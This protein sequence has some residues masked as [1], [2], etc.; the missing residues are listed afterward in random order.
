MFARLVSW[1]AQRWKFVLLL[2]GVFVAIAFHAFRQL[3]IEAYPD[4]TDPMVEVVTLLPGQ[5][6]E[7]TE[8]Q[9]S[10]ELERVLAGAP[11]LTNIR[12]V[13]VF[14][15]SVVTLRF[16]DS[17]TDR[18]N[19][20][21][22]AERLREAELPE[23]VEALLGPQATPVGQIY[24][25]T[26]S[27]AR[28][29][30]DLRSLQDWVIERRLRAVPGV[31]DV[32]TF[33][34]V[35]RQYA[36]RIDPVRL[37]NAEITVGDVYDAIERSNQN[38]GGGYVGIGNQEFVVRG[39][40]VLRRPSDIGEA[41]VAQR[42]GVPIRVKDVASVFESSVPRRGAVGRNDLD[43]VVEGIVLLRRGENPERVLEALQEQVDELNGEI[44]PP[45]VSIH[46]FYDRRELT[47]YTLST[48]GNNL[49]HGA[50][51]VVSI[52]L[53]FLRSWSAALIIAC[54]IPLSLLSSFLGL[55]ALGMSANLISMGAID[56]GILVE[57]AAVLLEVTLHGLAVQ[58]AQSTAPLT[59]KLRRD[60]IAKAALLVARPIGLASMIIIL[61]LVPLFLLERVEGRIFRPMAFTYVFAL[62]GGVFAA[63]TVVPAMAGVLLPK[64]V[65]HGESRWLAWLQRLYA[66]T[67]AAV[68]PRRW[69]VLGA[70]IILTGAVGFQ[71][72]TIGSEFLPELNE[73]GL[74]ITAVFPPTISLD[75]TRRHVPEI[76]RKLLELP[77]AVEVLSH[78][79]RPDDA[80]QTEGPN[81]A[82]FFVKLAPFEDWRPAFGLVELEQELRASLREVPGVN[83]N[84]SQPITDRVFETISGIIGQVV[85]KVRG[86]DLDTL[87]QIAQQVQTR[88]A[89]VE[90]IADLSL[91]QAGSIPQIGIELDRARL[92][93]LGLNVADAQRVV[94][95]ALGGKVATEVWEGERRYGVA[96]RLPEAVRKDPQAIGR[97]VLGDAERRVQLSDVAHISS[98]LGRASIWRENLSR[99]VAVK[100]N[101]RGRDLGSV[102]ADARAAVADLE[103]PSGVSL[104]FSGEFE[105]QQRAMS[106]LSVIVPLVLLAMLG[107]LYW[108]FGRWRPAV[109]IMGFLPVSTIFALAGLQ[110]MGEHFSVSAAVGCITLLGQVTLAGVLLCT[111]IDHSAQEGARDPTVEGAT[112]ALR[113]VLLTVCLAAIG[114]VP[115][116]LSHGMGSESQRPFA[117]AI[118]S[119]LIATVPLLLLIL[120]LVHQ[121]PRAQT[122]AEGEADAS[123]SSL[124]PRAAAGLFVLLFALGSTKPIQAAPA[125]AQGSHGAAPNA[126]PVQAAPAPQLDP[127]GAASNAAPSPE[128]VTRSRDAS[129]PGAS[130]LVPDD[131]SVSVEQLLQHWLQHSQEVAAWRAEVG[132][133]RFDLVTARTFPNLE[134]SLEGSH[135][136][137][138]EPPDGIINY[139]ASLSVPLPVFGQL[140]ART[141]A[142]RRALD[143]TEASVAMRLWER[144]AQIR[145][146]AMQRAYAE[147]RVQYARRALDELGRVQHVIEARS[148]AG[149][150]PRYDAMRVGLLNETLQANEQLALL[151]RNHAEAVIVG[152]IGDP[153]LARANVTRDGL[154]QLPRRPTQSE[155]VQWALQ[156]RPDLVLARRSQDAAMAQANQLKRE[157]IPIPHLSVGTYVTRDVNSVSLLGGLSLPLPVFDRNQGPIGRARSEARGHE[158]MVVALE[159]RTRAEVHGALH[160]LEQAHQARQ[161]FERSGVEVTTDLLDRAQRAYEAGSFSITELLDAHSAVWDARERLLEM[162]RAV[163]EAELRLL[164]SAALGV[165]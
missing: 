24:R 108:N 156:R 30:R 98:T 17:S 130:H 151:D 104:R 87:T 100:F 149:V 72:R 43:D 38:A 83:Y 102:V 139:G 1:S 119:G 129:A 70:A 163:A 123:R 136:L 65:A 5:S 141:Q 118:I 160:S 134:L 132:A 80:T 155:V 106:R 33:G 120:P 109:V 142:A 57:N 54:V 95:V 63:L 16:D 154:P 71:S 147:A 97:L 18:A 13:S 35:E 78:I 59:A 165:R 79:G 148:R 161:R 126:A 7:E 29:L 46:P 138:G 23:G 75:E 26:L 31:A 9:V 107:I 137:S 14:G 150:A 101:V 110:L 115:A 41:L 64:R 124:L 76:R 92:G 146:A 88:L 82:E 90:G 145:E 158:R 91:Y 157:A 47:N 19:R 81:N 40:G 117:I 22:V 12:T 39:V 48:V 152:L 74:Y 133:A 6:A 2:T 20:L 85:V 143:A 11:H 32:V 21:H 103:L 69:T 4:V 159:A 58:Q 127:H 121:P 55:R 135:T 8:R 128:A 112:V 125:A 73:G 66:S 42:D 56:F 153:N 34:G 131:A 116:A 113:P 86:E 44:L 53:L 62:L 45:D 61:A 50:L 51:L 111:R 96:L 122:R 99:F 15:L 144:S 36:V 162:E 164:H 60:A 84:F 25:Y 3:P 52:A 10:L 77:E 94:E 28:S 93:E 89:N 114:L 49:L 68:R 27:G 37:A 140:G 105:N 67:L